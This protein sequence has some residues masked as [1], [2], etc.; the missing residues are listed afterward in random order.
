MT[1]SF[2]LF[3]YMGISLFDYNSGIKKLTLPRISL[4]TSIAGV[5]ADAVLHTPEAQKAGGVRLA[6]ANHRCSHTT[7]VNAKPERNVATC[8]IVQLPLVFVSIFSYMAK[9]IL[10]CILC[11]EPWPCAENFSVRFD[12]SWMANWSVYLTQIKVGWVG[13]LVERPYCDVCGWSR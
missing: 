11:Q 6:G 12:S 13:A 7:T 1:S 9:Y 8:F 4:A 5:W 10:N 3:G 2:L